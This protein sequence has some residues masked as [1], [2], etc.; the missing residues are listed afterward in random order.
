VMCKL[1]G[2]VRAIQERISQG[3]VGLLRGGSSY[4]NMFDG[5]ARQ[6]LFTLAS[7]GRD[8]LLENV[9]GLGFLAL[10]ALSP[11]RLLKVIGLSLGTWLNYTF[12]HL[13]G[14][15]RPG[16]SHLS[17]LGSVQQIFNTVIFREVTTF[18][19]MI[20]I[21][22]GMPAI[23]AAYTGYDETAHH[24]GANNR[25]GLRVL[26]GLDKQIRQ[27][28]RLR[29]LYRRRTY[30][31]YILSDH[32]MSPALPFRQAHG[33]TLE[34]F[35]ATHTGQQV[36]EVRADGGTEGLSEARL[37]FLVDEIRAMESRRHHRLSVWLLRAARQRLE[38]ALQAQQIEWDLSRR[39]EIEVR[40]SGSLSHLY[41]NVVP[42]PMDLSEVALLYPGL[43][44][45]LVSHPGIGLTVGREGEE[46]AILGSSGTLWL[47]PA[48]RRL[49][50]EDPLADQSDPRWA[51]EQISRLARFP[52]AG[53]LFLLGRWDG[54]R[55]VTFE[56]QAATHGGLGGPQDWPFLLFPREM[57]FRSQAVE[58]SE[59]IYA[60]LAHLYGTDA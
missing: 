2:S 57:Q 15:V 47:G 10:F 26:R 7:V 49:E 56:D 23:Y 31:L 24:F 30:D 37:Y 59:E 11:I 21:Y 17:F 13:S 53:D 36:S 8:H 34:Q 22:R 29:Q 46:V 40:N 6:A 20:D 32:G 28:D 50:G 4:T 18:G 33:L 25:E 54:E 3:R 51:A 5:D 43:L 14:L 27:I 19:T 52:H 42:R 39:G 16:D 12:R 55:V 9:R 38:E 45:A 35:L 1:P 48:G 58:N 60:W 44:E 41:F